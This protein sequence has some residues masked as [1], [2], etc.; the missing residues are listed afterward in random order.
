MSIVL[1]S[2]KRQ[3]VPSDLLRPVNLNYLALDLIWDWFII[4]FFSFLILNTNYYFYP[5]WGVIIAGRF[6]ALGVIVHD[7]CHMNLKHKSLKFRV[8]EIFS[9]YIIGTSANAMA[10][11]HIRHHRNTLKEQDP[12]YNINKKCI[13]VVRFWLTLKKGLFFV[14]FWITRSFVAPFA[15]LFPKLRTPYARI[16]L[17]DIS[18]TDLS[19]DEEVISCA[20]ADLPIM[21]FHSLFFYL[22]FFQ[23]ESLIYLYYFIMPVS[24]MFCIYRL[25]IEHEYDIV[26]D[27]SVYTMIESTFDHHMSFLEK[28]FIGPHN[29]GFHSIHH[30]HPQVGHHYLKS[31]RN[32][33]L[34]HSKQ[35]Q[36]KYLHPKKLSWKQDLFGGIHN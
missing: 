21:I 33:Y 16:F 2:F 19:S 18:K 22:A 35:Y 36:E 20:K 32:W 25:L 7:L 27:R 12:Y 14:P 4:G 13:G 34:T 5:L 3:D 10:Y 6:H 1:E 11:H 31:V 29:I 30:I 28:W 17:Q 8:L 24:G 23:F 26:K 15:L 9:G